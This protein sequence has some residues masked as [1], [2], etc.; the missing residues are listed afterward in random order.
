MASS[1]LPS[2]IKTPKFFKIS[3]VLKVK[4]KVNLNLKVKLLLPTEEIFFPCNGISVFWIEEKI[5]KKSSY[6]CAASLQRKVLQ[7]VSHII[8][9]SLNR[10]FKNVLTIFKNKNFTQHPFYIFVVKP[11]KSWRQIMLFTS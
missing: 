4:V 5:C 1:G 10:V 8:H 6:N 7:A 3:K 9:R 11:L 2:L